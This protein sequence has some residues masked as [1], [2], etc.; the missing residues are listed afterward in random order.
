[1]SQMARRAKHAD[2]RASRTTLVSRTAFRAL[3]GIT[4]A[5]LAIWEEEEFITPVSRG[6]NVGEPLY[7][8]SAIR[9]ARLIRTLAEQLEVNVPGIGVI[10]HL[11]DQMER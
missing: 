11:L 9:R 5:E 8:T 7:A 4:E 1:M 3:A 10:L 6:D 2:R